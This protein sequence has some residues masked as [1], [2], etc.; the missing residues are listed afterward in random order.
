MR[1]N[2]YDF[3]NEFLDMTPKS[4]TTKENIDKLGFMRTK[5]SVSQKM[6]YKESEKTT[7]RIK[8]NIHK[9]YI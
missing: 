2:L 5:S 7:Y 1:I 3:A 6:H 4:L 8:E 9:S